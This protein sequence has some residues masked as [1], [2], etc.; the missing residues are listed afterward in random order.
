M[1]ETIS[2]MDRMRDALMD[3]AKRLTRTAYIVTIG[4]AINLGVA[5]FNIFVMY[6]LWKAR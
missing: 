3:N 1:G 2:P 5:A 6:Q 4:A